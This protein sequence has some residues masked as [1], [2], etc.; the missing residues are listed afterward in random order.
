MSN[1][2]PHDYAEHLK[3]TENYASDRSLLYHWNGVF[4]AAVSEE[5]GEAMAYEWLVSTDRA[6]ASPR[7]ANAAHKAAILWVPLLPPVPDEF[8]I[9]CTNGYVRISNDGPV[10]IAPRRDWGV[11]YSLSC[12]YD[13]A[14]PEPRRFKQFIERVLPDVDVR[15]RV[16]EYAG[17]TLTAD[18][19]HQRAQFWIGGGANGK[20]VLANVIQ[21]LHGYVAAI[22]LDG[23]DGFKL[24]VLIGASLI[25]CDEA[26]RKNI[27]EQLLK[28]LIAG[29]RVFVDRKYKDPL[30]LCVMGKWLVLGN[31]LPRI[32]DHSH[33]FWRR[34]DIV[35]FNVTIPEVEQDPLLAEFIIR[36][37]LPGVLAWALEGLMRLQKR[38]S[39]DPVLPKAMSSALHSARIET[40]SVKAWCAE[41]EV[42][43][44]G[45]PRLPKS[46]VYDSYVSWCRDNGAAA[47][48]QTQFWIRI[49][50]TFPQYIE[51]KIRRDDRSF[52][53]CNLCVGPA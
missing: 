10:L 33:G 45:V 17:Y 3:Q 1:F 27:N 6:N 44:E 53:T 18:A 49:R 15:Q 30:S 47:I 20:G 40:N 8:V 29:E 34:W 9:P 7:N 43:C 42:S 14:G 46:D 12:P 37:E 31:H 16:Q 28:S 32:E 2:R 38:G 35:P 22:S 5:F 11:Q 4:W 13:V 21:A 19:R 50:D 26:P 51:H 36:E 39:F 25:Y 24:S 52:R 41:D 48:G 23:L